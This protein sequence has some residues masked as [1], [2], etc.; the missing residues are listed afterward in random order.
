MIFESKRTW[1]G[2]SLSGTFLS[3]DAGVGMDLTLE[4]GHLSVCRLDAD[5]SWPEPGAPGIWSVTRTADELSVVCPQGQEPDGARVEPGWRV[6]RVAGPLAFDLVGVVA[7]L[8]TPLANAGVG[9]FI[10]STFD[11]DLLLVK[12][13]DIDRALSALRS[14]G[15]VVHGT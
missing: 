2:G 9:I 15:H 8:A 10:V 14:A 1:L 4:D 6:F 12:E 11:T 5:T 13:A 3:D 7:S